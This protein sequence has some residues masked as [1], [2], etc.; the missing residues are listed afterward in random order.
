[1]TIMRQIDLTEYELEIKIPPQD[2]KPD[3]EKFRY[4]V[5]GSLI[6]VLFAPELQLKARDILD[7]DDLAR[8]I[9]DWKNNLLILEEAEFEKL[10][11]AIENAG[12][13]G[14]NEI[15]L[16]RRILE[17]PQVEVEVKK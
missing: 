6:E 4:D 12:G 1:M 5:R 15:Q 9:R 14:R 3:T 2:G 10:K 8:K 7:R 11:H 17:A 16:I 13:L